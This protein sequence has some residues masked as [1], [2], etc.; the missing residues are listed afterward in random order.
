MSPRS[1]A[2]TTDWASLAS[3]SPL[4]SMSIK[5]MSDTMVCARATAVIDC[6]PLEALAWLFD[7]TS[8]VRMRDAQEAGDVARLTVARSSNHDDV[9]ATVKRTP[10]QVYGSEGVFRRICCKDKDELLLAVQRAED[11]VDYGTSVKGRRIKN[12]NWAKFSPVGGDLNSCKIT[13]HIQVS[14]SLSVVPRLLSMVASMRDC[15]QR[16][17]EIDATERDKLA[18]IIQNEE[19]TYSADE[20]LRMERVRST[21]SAL[22]EKDFEELESPDHLVKMRRQIVMGGSSG[23]TV[24]ASVVIDTSAEQCAA[25]LMNKG[26]RKS[27]KDHA[28]AGGGGTT[29]LKQSSHRHTQRIRWTLAIFALAPREW[30]LAWVWKWKDPSTLEV[31]VESVEHSDFPLSSKYVRCSVSGLFCLEVLP[32]VENVK[33]TRLTRTQK[34]DL[35][36]VIPRRLVARGAIKQLTFQSVMRKQFDKTLE[37]DGAARTRNMVLIMEHTDEYTEKENQILDVGKVRFSVFGSTRAKTIGMT[38]P[39][40][41]AKI[42]Y[43]QGDNHAWGWATTS[44]R[45]RPEEVLALV[46]DVDRRTAFRDDDVLRNVDEQVNGHNRLHYIR[47]DY[48]KLKVV[49]DRDFLNRCIWKKDGQGGF[50]YVIT[51]EESGEH[52]ARGIGAV[53]GK[54]P[55][56]MNIKRKWNNETTIEYVIRPDA[57]GHIPNFIMTMQ[58]RKSLGRLQELQEYFFSLRGL[59]EW[60][61]KDGVAVGEMLV[62][63]TKE[64]KIR[65]L[66]KGSMTASESFAEARMRA[67]LGNIRGLR[68]ATARYAW[69]E[70]MLGAVVHNKLRIA[71][72]MDCKM[73][74]VSVREGRTVGCGL[75]MALATNLTAEAG[76]QDWIGRYRCLGELDRA[77]VWFRPMMNVV[78]ERLLG[79]VGWGLKM[80]VIVGAGLSI[81][82]MATDMFMIVK[83]MG[84]EETRGYGFSLLWMVS[85]SILC[86]LLMVCVQNWRAPKELAK[87]VLI[88]FTGLKPA[89]EAFK[90]VSG[91]EM[92]KHHLFDAKTELVATKSIEMVCENVPGCIL[93]VYVILRGGEVSMSTVGSV[94][95]SALT[96]GYTSATL[97]YDYDVSPVKRRELPGFYG[98]IPDGG[99]RAMIFMCMMLNSALLLLLR[100][101]SA[102]FLILAGGGRFAGYVVVD[103]GVYLAWKVAQCDFWYWIP[104]NGGL[105]LTLSLIIRV[106]FKVLVDYAGVLH[107]RSPQDLGGVYF[108]ANMFF[109]LAGCFVSVWVGGGGGAEW[110]IVWGLSVGWLASFGGILKLMK[111]EYRGSFF[112]FKT[113][114]ESTM[115]RWASDDEAVKSSM[116][117]KNKR[118]WMKVRG[119]VREWV[120]GNWWRW[121]EERPKWFNDSFVAKVPDDFI[122]EDVDMEAVKLAKAKGRR[123]S[124]VRP[125]LD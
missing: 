35:R 63:K 9:V 61:K 43:E 49:R 68:E 114:K 6:A 38:S 66:K 92:A 54:Y 13:Y 56:T 34:T 18:T 27:K 90:V 30:V 67:L 29:V 95:M 24:Q 72:D 70:A 42:A 96:T 3:P 77:E 86:Q 22:K 115:E 8:R 19:Q 99:G 101:F 41:T 33:R 110:A 85:G 71:A 50:V 81:M 100:S 57:G 40:T 121:Q 60:D 23:G 124:R 28:N 93:Q 39:L 102:A 125:A 32:S 55:S 20:L 12:T 16:D 91:K 37:I 107:F 103:I 120:R 48:K 11:I 122:P 113:A 94:V 118:Q 79:E 105:G 76:V 14:G 1:T 36:G 123:S 80:R 109:A 52:A 10:M 17:Y 15:M 5:R 65:E 117:G 4:V 98:Y 51:P 112:S 64:E 88:T 106:V 83:Y 75:A 108:T 111:K 104:V 21:F 74:D 116:L 47:K 46:W 2:V 44:V 59:E 62:H 25:W 84:A 53:R 89:A 7:F 119:E 58:M 31:F 26:S 82:D 69:L 97:S 73:C 87:E 78:G 45:A